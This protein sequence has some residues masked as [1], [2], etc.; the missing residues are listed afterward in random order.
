MS[1]DRGRSTAV[2]VVRAWREDGAFRATVTFSPD[3]VYGL[4]A[5]RGAATGPEGVLAIVDRW[6]QEIG[7]TR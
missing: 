3:V 7:W 6:L 1:G 5:E 4:Q 2:L